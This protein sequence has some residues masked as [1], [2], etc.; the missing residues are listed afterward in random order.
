MSRTKIEWTDFTWNPV[1][2]CLHRCPYCYGEKI[3]KRF[4]KLYP[5][6][7][8]PTFHPERLREPFK[9]SRNFR[10]RNPNLSEGAAM[11]FTVSMGD[12][13]GSWMLEDRR[14]WVYSVFNTIWDIYRSSPLLWPRHQFQILTKAPQNIEFLLVDRIP[15][16]VWIGTTVEDQSK[17]WRIEHIQNLK[18]HG[19]KFVSFEPLLGPI[20]VDL[21]GIDWVII[22][23][24]TNPYRP[25]DPGWVQGLIVRAK[26]AGAAVFLK[27]NLRWPFKIQEFP[28]VDGR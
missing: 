20:E 18:H 11:I 16:N 8:K 4:K 28:E 26:D 12:L 17:T 1:T 3:A 19:I 5:N 15:P 2:G 13:F 9:V 24:Q 7:Y 14:F 6:G 27:D 23:A 22:G 10:S 21:S 25:P